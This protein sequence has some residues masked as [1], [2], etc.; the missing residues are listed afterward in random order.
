M[1]SIKQMSKLSGALKS[2]QGVNWHPGHMYAGMKAMIGKLHTV[3]CVI[4]VHD[5]RIP[6]TGRHTQLRK[7]LSIK[8]R[9]LVLNKRD[10][11][12]LSKWDS[13]KERLHR[14]GD[15]NVLLTDLTGSQFSFR[16]RGYNLILDD[17]V[18]A[19]NNSDRYN[20][21]LMDHFKIMIVGIPN[22][23]KSTLIN[24]L[25][26]LHLGRKGEPAKC[27]PQAGVTRTVEN[28]IKICSRPPIYTLDTPGVLE[29]GATRDFDDSMR[30]ALCS[31]INDTVLDPEQVAKYLLDYLNE[32]Q[33]YSYQRSFDLEQPAKSLDDLFNAAV[34][35]EPTKSTHSVIST[36]TRESIRVPD[37]MKIC[38]KFIKEFRAGRYGRVM[39]D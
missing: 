14:E 34:A 16:D 37:S 18:K 2:S 32:N 27:G 8:P 12:D 39:F 31:T 4:E 5:A 23:G 28:I 6:F 11:A 24:R 13:I 3:D 20:R 9:L 29:P 36:G 22:V 25:R 10:L 38:W 26:Q 21:Q 15:E 19:I 1:P 35:L 17:V 7:Q 30:L 33:N